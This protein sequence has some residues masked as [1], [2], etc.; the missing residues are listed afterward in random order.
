M[1][2]SRFQDLVAKPME[3]DDQLQK[4]DDDE[5]NEVRQGNTLYG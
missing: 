5:I 4:P 2:H 1:V 3:D